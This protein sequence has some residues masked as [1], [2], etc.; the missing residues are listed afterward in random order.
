VS[1]VVIAVLAIIWVVALT[2]M[3]LRKLSE[4]RFTTSVDSFH[5]QLRGMRRAY[6]R[7]AASAA[8]PE[9][10]L[11]IA[12]MA[13]EPTRYPSEATVHMSRSDAVERRSPRA[14]LT[15]ARRRRVLVVLGAAM[16][17]FFVLGLV[18]ALRVL[19]GLSLLVL[20]AAAGYL[21]LLI[22]IHRRSVERRTKV[23]D[24]RDLRHDAG[25]PATPNAA[26][27]ESSFRRRSVSEEMWEED[28][29]LDSALA[30]DYDEIMA[31]GR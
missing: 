4:R 10:A 30:Y 16:L 19:W 8:D 9:A 2:P 27:R 25:E 28:E 29:M 22:Y 20:A 7:L 31:G 26:S 6:P 3:L 1:L 5:R 24:I 18:P 15:A 13:G 21:A 17:G 11:F 12:E 23:V 14:Q